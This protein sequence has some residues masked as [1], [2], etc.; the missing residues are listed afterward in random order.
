MDKILLNVGGLVSPPDLI[1]YYWENILSIYLLYAF[2][3]VIVM[4]MF[5]ENIWESHIFPFPEVS[6]SMSARILV[7][8]PPSIRS[9]LFLDSK[10]IGF[11]SSW[12]LWNRHVPL[13]M[14]CLCCRWSPLLIQIDIQCRP[15]GFSY[16]TF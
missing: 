3:P 10:N 2:V 7:F 16:H 8:L 15:I 5:L 12:S 9:C 1:L 4:H 11:H 13:L 6:H 14:F